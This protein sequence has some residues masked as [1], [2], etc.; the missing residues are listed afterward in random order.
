M[1]DID[2]KA[3]SANHIEAVDAV[4]SKVLIE[5]A[6]IGSDHEHELAPWAA[7]KAYPMAVFWCLMVSMC[8]VMVSTHDIPNSQ[9]T[10]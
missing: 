3:D 8:V 5:N 2:N 10:T 7:I 1:A 6:A 4:P 9:Q